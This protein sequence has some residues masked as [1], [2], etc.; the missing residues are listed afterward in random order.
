MVE[1][2]G[3]LWGSH[4]GSF[5]TILGSFWS[6]LGPGGVI[7]IILGVGGGTPP[8][9]GVFLSIL[10]SKNGTPRP[11]PWLCNFLAIFIGDFSG[12]F[13][14]ADQVRGSFFGPGGSFLTFWGGYPPPQG[15]VPGG[16]G[17]PPLGGSL[18]GS[19]LTILGSFLTI[20]G[21]FLGSGGAGWDLGSFKTHDFDGFWGVIE[22]PRGGRAHL[23][24]YDR[25]SPKKWHF[26][27]VLRTFRPKN[28]STSDLII[29][30]TRFTFSIR[31]L[32][33]DIFTELIWECY[34]SGGVISYF[35]D[36]FDEK[37]VKKGLVN[38]GHLGVLG[39]FF[40]HFWSL[41]IDFSYLIKPKIM[42]PE[43]TRPSFFWQTIIFGLKLIIFGLFLIIFR[44]IFDHL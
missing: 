24:D 30:C 7:L 9:G 23:S 12:P 35:F 42:P 16:G 40:G 29:V 5:L 41:F 33:G 3:T 28:W 27:R 17:S 20:W 39:R 44:V 38:H 6:F 4:F 14:V 22:T 10:G 25:K 11:P 34:P 18:L 32:V 43:N 21:T 19:F 13:L 8:R 36:T 37:F 2:G 15:G 26:I 1:G 31:F